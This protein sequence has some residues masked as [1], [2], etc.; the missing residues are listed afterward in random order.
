MKRTKKQIICVFFLIAVLCFGMTLTTYAEDNDSI[1]IENKK[2]YL[3]TL[4]IPKEYFEYVSEEKISSMFDRYS[5][6][7]R[8]SNDV[9]YQWSH[10]IVEEKD[11]QDSNA[12]TRDTISTSKLQLTVG[13]MNELDATNASSV[14]GVVAEVYFKWLSGP[15]MRSEDALTLNWSSSVFNCDGMIAEVF[16]YVDGYYAECGYI[17][18]PAKWGAGG[19]GWGVP[20]TAPGHP[21]EIVDNLQ[22]GANIHLIPV[23]PITTSSGT[24]C[25]LTAEYTH[26][27]LTLTGSVNFDLNGASV[28][29]SPAL[30][31][32]TLNSSYTWK[33]SRYSGSN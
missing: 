26:H 31:Q 15:Q 12:K 11:M 29:V 6:Q 17:E 22:G 24:Q 3:M 28:S 33:A 7:T 4:G 13:Y 32:D 10:Y 8:S 20:L 27:Y 2:E 25:V 5:K 23:N 21:G 18:Q 1:T 30:G 19:V 14:K 9:I 16:G